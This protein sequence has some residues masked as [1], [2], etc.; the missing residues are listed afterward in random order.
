MNAGFLLTIHLDASDPSTLYSDTLGTTIINATAS[1]TVKAIGSKG[2]VGSVRV[3]FITTNGAT[4]LPGQ[5]NGNGV[6]AGASNVM[7][8]YMVGNNR[9]SLSAALVGAKGNGGTFVIVCQP[10]TY[11]SPW[12]T[13]TSG[14]EWI[15]MT[16]GAFAIGFATSGRMTL[17]FSPGNGWGLIYIRMDAVAKTARYR[18]RQNNAWSGAEA[19]M[20]ATTAD[21]FFNSTEFVDWTVYSYPTYP[22]W[23]GKLGELLVYNY[24]LNDTEL[25]SVCAALITKWAV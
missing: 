13:P 20:A 6:L 10:G 24:P 23:D 5:R 9:L 3:A 2:A 11:G 12:R 8:N 7:G 18:A 15:S 4:F 1:A 21:Q 19:T 25:N 16:N 14:D 17:P 22:S